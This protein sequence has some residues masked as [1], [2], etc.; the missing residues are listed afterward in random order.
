MD[1]IEKALRDLA[2]AVESNDD[3]VSRITVTITFKKPKPDKANTK[4]E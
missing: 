1:K 3:I 2:Q 4:A